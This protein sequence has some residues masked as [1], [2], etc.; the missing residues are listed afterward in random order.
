MF[1]LIIFVFC[2][3]SVFSWNLFNR[4]S[5]VSEDGEYNPNSV[6]IYEGNTNIIKFGKRIPGIEE[7][8]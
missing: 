5:D 1:R 8:V 7:N 6:E 2:C 4:S 3:S